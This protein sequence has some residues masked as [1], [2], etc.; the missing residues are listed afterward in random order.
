MNY[1]L[2]FYFLQVEEGFE[3][4]T[5]SHPESFLSINKTLIF[6]QVFIRICHLNFKSAQVLTDLNLKSAH[7]DF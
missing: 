5:Q 4:R 1:H 2:F 3:I 7:L 6:C